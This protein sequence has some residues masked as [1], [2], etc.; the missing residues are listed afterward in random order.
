MSIINRTPAFDNDL[1]TSIPSLNGEISFKNVFFRVRLPEHRS[2]FSWNSHPSS[3]LKASSLP[4]ATTTKQMA[5]RR[6]AINTSSKARSP[7][8]YRSELC[9]VL[10]HRQRGPE[11]RLRRPFRLR[12]VD[13]VLSLAALLRH[14]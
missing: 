13:L 12:E 14:H 4:Q 10:A 7:L 2:F 6:S 5:R 8:L 1:G 9:R 3:I 11:R